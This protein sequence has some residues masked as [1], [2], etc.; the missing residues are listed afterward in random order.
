MT[1]V[2]FELCVFFLPSL[3]LLPPDS[4]SLGSAEI[5]IN[6]SCFAWLAPILNSSQCHSSFV[7]MVCQMAVSVGVN[8]SVIFIWQLGETLTRSVYTVNAKVTNGLRMLNLASSLAHWRMDRCV[9]QGC[10]DEDTT[11][12]FENF[13]NFLKS[14]S[15]VTVVFLILKIFHF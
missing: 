5:I 14:W 9:R 3:F 7:F 6:C 15:L 10:V 4:S 2:W 1:C 13:L 11:V 8:F 12:C